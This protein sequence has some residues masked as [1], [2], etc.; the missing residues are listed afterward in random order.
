[1]SRP[2]PLSEEETRKVVREEIDSA[3]RKQEEIARKEKARQDRLA[4]YRS[5]LE[6][7]GDDPA[8]KAYAEAYHQVEELQAM[9][10]AALFTTGHPGLPP[11]LLSSHLYKLEIA[12]VDLQPKAKKN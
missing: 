11:E 6:A 7:A 3:R 1:M 12:L 9:V 2:K 5:M 8:R 10:D 4:R